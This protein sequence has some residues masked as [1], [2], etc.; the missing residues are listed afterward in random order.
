MEKISDDLITKARKAGLEEEARV[1]D[2]IEKVITDPYQ[3]FLIIE[4]AAGS[5]KTEYIRHIRKKYD[6]FFSGGGRRIAYAAPS[7]QAAS[8]LRLRNISLALTT[9]KYMSDFKSFN[10][11]PNYTK[12]FIIDEASLLTYEEL[13]EVY[14]LTKI[15]EQLKYIFLGDSGQ[16]YPYSF[17]KGREE[18]KFTALEAEEI[19]KIF[20]FKTIYIV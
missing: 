9:Q 19:V 20:N 1:K 8:N 11:D 7:R 18:K 3:R 4:G 6:T 5:G 16:N 15:N 10:K 17:I 2:A 12:L 14:E 13:V